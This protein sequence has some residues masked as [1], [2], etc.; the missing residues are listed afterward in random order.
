MLQRKKWDRRECDC[1]KGRGQGSFT[2]S[3]FELRLGE[4]EAH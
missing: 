1:F 4:G 2:E 3:G